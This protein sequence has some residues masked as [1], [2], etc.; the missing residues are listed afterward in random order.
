MVGETISKYKIV[1]KIGDGGMGSV[2]EAV[3]E[4]IG[5]RAAVKILHPKY[6]KDP[7]VVARFFNEA[8]AVNIVQHPG[9]VGVFDYGTLPDQTAYIIMEYLDGESL[10]ARLKRLG[11][12]GPDALRLARQI[13]GTL[14][15]AHARGIIHR[16]LKPDNIII[17]ADPEAPGGERAKVLDFG[18]AKISREAAE[19]DADSCMTQAG[20]VMGTPKYMSPEQCRG[21]GQIDA[22]AD[23]YSL[24]VMLF[25]MY[26]GQLPFS[27]EGAGALLAMHIYKP[28]PKL[29][30][31]DPTVAPALEGLV[32]AMLA[33][34]PAQ[35]PSMIEVAQQL[36]MLGA[37]G[38]QALPVFALSS[39]SMSPGVMPMAGPSFP[40]FPGGV[41]S[42]A[43]QPTPEAV[44]AAQAPLDITSTSRS[45]PSLV[46]LLAGQ[47]ENPTRIHS[48][49]QVLRR[50]L[51]PAATGVVVFVAVFAIVRGQ[52][53]A[54]PVPP[55]TTAPA[56]MPPKIVWSVSS[57]PPGAR[58][59]RESD[60][61]VVG[62]TPWRLERP[63]AQGQMD[64]TLR[65]EGFKDQKLSLKL[66][67]DQHE[68]VLL[69]PLP[70]S[71]PPKA[72]P[73]RTRRPGPAR[74]ARPKLK[75][76]QK[77]DDFFAPVR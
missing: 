38:T 63:A 40:S 15:A 9:I 17:V 75:E 14:A 2:F 1:R 42:G 54:A 72:A 26:T 58:V 68:S 7:T 19:R 12:L 43:V 47:T 67:Q 66:D 49:M 35:R 59:I 31:F 53:T 52:R 48:R 16:D 13:A 76:T 64:I 73:P 57:T 36:E 24:G 37:K 28:P 71:P 25:E 20:M 10:H 46:G 11:R 33:K 27:A 60:G 18:I 55:G 8:R 70:P 61:T 50:L 65:H 34:E 21:A 39:Q 4:S 74:S 5:R 6:S 51:I 3:H 44:S 32:Q 56:P 22:K 77:D 69:V 23:V 30:E 62:V 45:Q 29:A 41:P